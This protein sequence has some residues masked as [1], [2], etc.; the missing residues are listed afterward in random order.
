MLNMS[1]KDTGILTMSNSILAGLRLSLHEK[2][3]T[4]NTKKDELNSLVKSISS[5][6][7]WPKT[8]KI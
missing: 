8:Q 2:D 7:Q 4:I 6:F 5:V 3:A 1:F